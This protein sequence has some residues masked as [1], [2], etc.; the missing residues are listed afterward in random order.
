MK[1][2]ELDHLD[3]QILNLLIK[4]AREPFTEIAKKLNVSG[5]TVHF[6]VRKLEE[7]GVIN[8]SNLNIS[9]EKLGYDIVAYLGINMKNSQLDKA[10]IEALK[11]VPEIV[12]LNITTGEYT[13][14]AKIVCKDTKNLYHVLSNKIQSIE[15]VLKTETFICLDEVL[16]KPLQ[17]M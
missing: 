7:A 4:D 17:I 11:S 9:P 1:A 12:E 6:R 3:K 5:G 15:G 10:G 13:L 14:L 2:V 16:S 8:G